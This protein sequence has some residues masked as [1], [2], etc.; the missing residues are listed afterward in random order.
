MTRI[1]NRITTPRGT[2]IAELP[3]SR[4]G[5]RKNAIVDDTPLVLEDFF[6]SSSVGSCMLLA[7]GDILEALRNR[8]MVDGLN[9]AGSSDFY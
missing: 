7:E 9:P 2:E 5:R 4:S 8:S 1:G 3:R 6:L